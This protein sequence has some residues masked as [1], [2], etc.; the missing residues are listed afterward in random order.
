MNYSAE[1]IVSFDCEGNVTIEGDR[2]LPTELR[3]RI[4]ESVEE[5]VK[6]YFDV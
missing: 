4:K 5:A 1:V 2:T 3:Y 6:Y